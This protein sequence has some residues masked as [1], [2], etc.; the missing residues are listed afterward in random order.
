MN[1]SV[2]V[3]KWQEENPDK[4][5]S[6]KNKNRE[7]Y[8]ELYD[9]NAK[10]KYNSLSPE[11]KKERNRLSSEKRKQRFKDD[12]EAWKKYYQK[13]KEYKVKNADKLKKARNLRQQK[14]YKE[15][16]SYKMTVLLRASF[17]KALKRKQ[18]KKTKSI[19]SIIGCSQDFLRGYLES[20]FKREMN[21]ENHGIL[22]EI[23][24]II[25]IDSFDLANIE[26]QYKCFHYSN[27]QPLFKT[28]EI[29]KLNGYDEIG[30]H[31]KS[32][33]KQTNGNES[34]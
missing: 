24:H 14:R 16:L 3:K 4:V 12:P 6:Y 15:D 30:N 26:E 34:N 25:P 7:L 2:Y 23:D 8:K 31:N 10:F 11:E 33:K 27:L 20:K 5:K 29:A 17:Y 9:N 32:N 19:I 1:K 21:W 22:W 13:R 28:T 18:G